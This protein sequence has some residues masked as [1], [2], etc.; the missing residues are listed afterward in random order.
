MLSD[1]KIKKRIAWQSGWEGR[2][3][4]HFSPIPSYPTFL[5]V[6]AAVRQDCSV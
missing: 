5:A 2:A 4:C 1:L 6:V 3:I